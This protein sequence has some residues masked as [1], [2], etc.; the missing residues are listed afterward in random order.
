MKAKQP[1]A[2]FKT[3]RIT[4]NTKVIRT[5]LKLLFA[6]AQIYNGTFAVSQMPFIQ[7]IAQ[8]SNPLYV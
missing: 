2:K 3:L 7:K 1:F 8:K 6:L 4:K 5:T